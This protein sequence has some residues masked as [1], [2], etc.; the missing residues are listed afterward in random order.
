MA[1]EAQPQEPQIVQPQ[2]M[3]VTTMVG[4]ADT[5]NGPVVVLKFASVNGEMT[6]FLPNEVALE[7]AGNIADAAQP[8]PR[9]VAAPPGFVVPR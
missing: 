5:T 9:L 3:P 4:T 6:Y 8:G 7:L 2:P 1:D